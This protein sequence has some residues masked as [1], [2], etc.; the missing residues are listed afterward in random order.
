[1][2]CDT[3]CEQIEFADIALASHV[4]RISHAEQLVRRFWPTRPGIL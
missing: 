2:L 3:M 1:M 4:G